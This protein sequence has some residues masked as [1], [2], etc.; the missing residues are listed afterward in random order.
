MPGIGPVAVSTPS[1][2]RATISSI[3]FLLFFLHSSQHPSYVTG[4]LV[5]HGPRG[6]DIAF[7]RR[8]FGGPGGMSSHRRVSDGSD[9]GGLYRC[10]IVDA[11]LYIY[12]EMSSDLQSTGGSVGI[13]HSWTGCTTIV[14]GN[15]HPR[16]RCCRRHTSVVW[17][18]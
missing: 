13:R 5:R 1:V 18:D 2:N 17:T 14:C 11:R 3:W 12:R 16:A 6:R 9:I 4:A 8:N 15:P 7:W 10:F